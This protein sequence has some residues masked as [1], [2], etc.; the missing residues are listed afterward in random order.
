MKPPL[1]RI[2]AALLLAVATARAEVVISEF[3]AE[4]DSGLADVDGAH[5]D[6]IEL[7]NN[8]A[9]SVTLTGWRLTDDPLLPA[10]WTFPTV[11][12]GAGARLVVFASGK[13]RAVPGQEL[14]TNFSIQNSGGYLALSKPDGT[15][16][17]AFNP[18]PA[19]RSDISFGDGTLVDAQDLVVATSAGKYLVPANGTLGTT[20]T[21][22]AFNDFGW[23]AATSRVGYQ[24]GGARPGLPIAYW[25]FDDTAA[26]EIAGAPVA[27][28]Y[29]AT[30]DASVPSA[31]T[32]GKSLHFTRASS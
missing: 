4:N 5:S 11:N 6:W 26:N 13:N 1:L 14:H 19:Q 21:A 29:G 8:G 25:T 32:F 28:L 31:V 23:P 22:P 20:W 16:T 3:L 10:R 12:I 15:I 27:T 24:T 17:R 9:A 7:F 18:Y 2:C 30:Y